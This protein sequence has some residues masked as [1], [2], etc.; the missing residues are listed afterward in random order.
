MKTKFHF[1]S[2]ISI[3]LKL[4]EFLISNIQKF[5]KKSLIILMVFI[6][7]HGLTKVLQTINLV[8]ELINKIIT[9][10][11]CNPP[12]CHQGNWDN[13]RFSKNA[14]FSW[15]MQKLKALNIRDV[16]HL[17]RH[18]KCSEKELHNFCNHPDAYYNEFVVK[19]KGKNRPIAQPRGRLKQILTNLQCLLS[20]IELPGYLHGGVKEH[21]PKTNALCHINK[22]AVFN[23]DLED[24]FPS[25]RPYMV[26]DLFKNRLGCRS[27]IAWILTQLVTFKDGL[28]QGSPTSTVVA[29][30]VIVP[31]SKRLNNLSKKHGCTYTQFVDDGTISGP[32]YIERLRPLIDK[33]ISQEGLRAS[34]KA[35]KRTTK[36]RHEEQLVTKVRVNKR[37]DISTEKLDEIRHE[38]DEL[39]TMVFRGD[40][41]LQKRINSLRG[42]IQYVKTLNPEKASK[43]NNKLTR[44]FKAVS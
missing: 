23:F 32:G 24:F 44:I 20:R 21:S 8:L 30:L 37:I 19:V 2:I 40:T 7:K 17:C 11:F 43:L 5:G 28:P 9:L 41:A 6:R 22:S 16:K 1:G 35:H 3:F 34:P 29:N 25:V 13:D 33:I 10:L 39:K 31:L 36:H 4:V 15:T 18:L 27:Q 42:K 14:R 38:L 12:R 26:Y